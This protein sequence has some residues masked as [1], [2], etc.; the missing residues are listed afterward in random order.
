M[1]PASPDDSP[2]ATAGGAVRRPPYRLVY[3]VGRAR[4]GSTLLGQ[5]IGSHSRAT[6]VG[7]LRAFSERKRRSGRC[8]TGRPC[9]CGARPLLQCAFW[10]RVDAAV[11]RSN[12]SGLSAVDADDDDSNRALLDAVHEVGGGGVI[13]D[14]SKDPRRLRVLLESNAC[15]IRPIHLVRSPFGVLFSHKRRGHDLAA[16]AASYTRTVIEISR[17]L[18]GREHLTVRYEELARK[19]RAVLERIMSW[20][21]LTLEQDQLRWASLE[22]H[23]IGGRPMARDGNSEIK[24][25]DDWKNGLSLTEKVRIGRITLPSRVRGTWLY[26][27]RPDLWQ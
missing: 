8:P 20:L 21:G 16:K 15:G 22:H 23:N 17:L 4:S 9:A 13:V 24:L 25:D 18:A 2:G 14:S 11:R 19:P 27:L 5:L 3:I 26:D 7:E 12:G 6:N 1:E 10:S